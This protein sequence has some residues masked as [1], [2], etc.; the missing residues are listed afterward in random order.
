M[1]FYLLL[2]A[3]LFGAGLT[4]LHV[5]MHS[6]V[7]MPLGALVALAALPSLDGSTRV[8]AAALAATLLIYWL[9]DSLRPR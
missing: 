7:L 6:W 9:T 8:L 3:A 1:I 2:A 5:S 4:M